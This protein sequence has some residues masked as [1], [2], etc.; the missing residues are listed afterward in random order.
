[1]TR[2]VPCPRWIKTGA[3][4]AYDDRDS[5]FLYPSFVST[6]EKYETLPEHVGETYDECPG[7]VPV[8]TKGFGECPE[9]KCRDWTQ[10]EV[11]AMNVSLEKGE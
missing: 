11:N 7:D 9:C 6:R 1:M 10:G 2:T 3:T 5:G 4:T 8:T